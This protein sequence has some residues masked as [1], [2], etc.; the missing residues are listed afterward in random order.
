MIMV[1]ASEQSSL[2]HFSLVPIVEMPAQD[3]TGRH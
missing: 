1:K 2:S 3:Y